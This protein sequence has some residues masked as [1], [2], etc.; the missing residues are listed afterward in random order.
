MKHL[1][2]RG[3]QP[4]AVHPVRLGRQ[5]ARRPA[6]ASQHATV[7]ITYGQ[8]DHVRIMRKVLN[9]PVQGVEI[10]LSR[11]AR[12]RRRSLAVERAQLFA[13]IVACHLVHGIQGHQRDHPDNQQVDQQPQADQAKTQ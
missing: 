5:L 7:A 8:I 12:Q 13:Q 3:K 9:L 6:S 4:E 2:A 1:V 10:V 11:R